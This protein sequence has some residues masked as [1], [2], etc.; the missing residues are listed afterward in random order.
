MK[1]PFLDLSRQHSGALGRDIAEAIAI[2]MR[3]GRFVLGEQV[4][5]FEAE[6]A[7]F[8]GFKHCV[9][10]ASGT[11]AIELALRACGIGRNGQGVSVPA[12]TAWGT[13]AGV[14]A[15]GGEPL[16]FDVVQPG[17]W[18][19]LS[20]PEHRECSSAS[21][22]V[23]LWGRC[24]PVP[25]KA[26]TIVDACQGVGLLRHPDHGVATCFSFYPTKNLGACGDGGAVCTNYATLADELRTLRMQGERQRFLSERRTGHS[27][28]DELQAAILRVKLPY[29]LGWC[30]TRYAFAQSYAVAAKGRDMTPLFPTA[31]GP[32]AYNGHLAVFYVPR[33]DEF[34]AHMK[35]RGI[36]TGVHYPTPI[37]RM[38]AM[39]G[40]VGDCPVAE[41][42]CEH[43]VSLPC[44]AEMRADEVSAV[45]DALAAWKG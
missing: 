18:A 10:C 42:L 6:F 26:T 43:I 1:V 33:R 39:Q 36:E 8:S 28:L 15:A 24:A 17:P 2:V 40:R 4:E 44:Y 19:G 5:A 3:R 9:S 45:C 37:H 16:V 41:D 12:L 7:S 14:I 34:R 29:V 30:A 31:G 22:V 38:P 13:V 25:D 27:R 35:R 11:D 23:D 21:V 32:Y 20:G